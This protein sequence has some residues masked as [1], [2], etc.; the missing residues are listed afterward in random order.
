MIV[1][2]MEAASTSAT[3]ANFYQTARPNIPKENHIFLGC[4]RTGFRGEY[5]M[6][7]ATG[8]WTKLRHEQLYNFLS[9][10]HIIKMVKFK[11][12]G[13][14]GHVASMGEIYTKFWSKNLKGR[15]FWETY[16]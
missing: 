16:E 13:M 12:D 5:L 6:Q 2:M 10:P 3:S 7:G 1:L 15:G 8:I 9:L 11:E 14:D 4:L